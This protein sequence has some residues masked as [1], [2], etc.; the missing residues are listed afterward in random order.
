[1]Q[2]DI[3]NGGWRF[4]GAWG[5]AFLGFP[6]GGL[7]GQALTGGVETA[8]DGLL[9]GAATGAV[10]GAAQWL[11]LRRRM[12]LNAWWIAATSG[13]MAVGL[14]VSVALFGSSTELTGL[15][16]RGL[17]TGSAI[18]VAQFLL[19]RPLSSAA[20]IWLLIVVIGWPIGWL[21]TRTAGVDLTPNRT[22]FGS[23]GAWVFQLLTGLALAWMFRQSMELGVRG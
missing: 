1:M 23:T 6:L 9:G 14:A 8:V 21:V 2:A 3:R 19:L 7:A 15:L 11:V 13:E 4:W 22:V 12:L 17:I 5:L 20:F 16:L 18:G 10:I